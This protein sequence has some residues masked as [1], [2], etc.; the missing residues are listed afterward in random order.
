MRKCETVYS[1]GVQQLRLCANVHVTAYR[2]YVRRR[3]RRDLTVTRHACQPWRQ[4]TH[5]WRARPT[6]HLSLATRPTLHSPTLH[7]T[8]THTPRSMPM[9]RSTPQLSIHSTRT[10]PTHDHVTHR[11][12]LDTFTSQPD[13][14]HHDERAAGLATRTPQT[15][16]LSHTHTT[17]GLVR[18]PLSVRS[19]RPVHSQLTRPRRSHVLTGGRARK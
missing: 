18:E 5:T 10:R 19:L 15:R 11:P 17:R 9:S 12:Q 14:S 4:P 6:T 7:A 3:R 8:G 1:R 16:H 13:T 2:S